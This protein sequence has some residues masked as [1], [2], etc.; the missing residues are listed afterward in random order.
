MNRQRDTTG[1]NWKP[2]KFAGVDQLQWMILLLAVLLG[3]LTKQLRFLSLP[4]W[5][6]DW[7]LPLGLVIVGY[8]IRERLSRVVCRRKSPPE[9]DTEE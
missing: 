1:S 3:T 5:F 7:V 8:N 4:D 6:L 9:D 2:G